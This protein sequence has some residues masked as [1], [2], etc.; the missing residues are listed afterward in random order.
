MKNDELPNWVKNM[1]LEDFTFI[2]KLIIAS[3]SLKDLAKEYE[4][5]YPTIRSRLNR[6]IEKVNLYD[7]NETDKYIEKIKDLAIDNKID[8][9]TAKVL[10]SEYRKVR[11]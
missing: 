5:S 11:S 8:L 10:I 7:S 2:K 3:G 6:L 4:I 9:N 1:E